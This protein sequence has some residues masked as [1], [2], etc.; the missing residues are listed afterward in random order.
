MLLNDELSGR[1]LRY[2][3]VEPTFCGFTAFTFTHDDSEEARPRQ[4]QNGG[5]KASIQR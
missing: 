4:T 5:P 1:S 3:L 2:S